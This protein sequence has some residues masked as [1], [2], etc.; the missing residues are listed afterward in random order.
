M[1]FLL[2]ETTMSTWYDIISIL[3]PVE[4]CS[5]DVEYV[6]VSMNNTKKII[7]GFV[8]FRSKAENNTM[9][10]RDLLYTYDIYICQETVCFEHLT[11][12]CEMFRFL[13]LHNVDM[14]WE[15]GSLINNTVKPVLPLSSIISDEDIRLLF[16]NSTTITK[17][18]IIE[19]TYEDIHI[20]YGVARLVKE[21][22][23]LSF[24]MKGYIN[25][26]HI[27]HSSGNQC[28][29]SFRFHKNPHYGL[30]L[31]HVCLLKWILMTA[32]VPFMEYEASETY[33]HN[34]FLTIHNNLIGTQFPLKDIYSLLKGCQ[35]RT[36]NLSNYFISY[37]Y[38]AMF[39]NLR[40]GEPLLTKAI[41]YVTGKRRQKILPLALPIISHISRDLKAYYP[42]IAPDNIRNTTYAQRMGSNFNYSLE[43]LNYFEGFDVSIMYEEDVIDPHCD[44]MNDWRDGYDYLSVVKSTFLDDYFDKYVTV[45]II[46]YTRKAIGDYMY[47]SG[48]NIIL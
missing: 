11:I 24:C 20:S 40:T 31:K 7:M 27:I 35:L 1:L 4:I 30:K 33:Y 39:R 13:V 37:G 12:G 21:T 19:E 46:C 42:N 43:G 48:V 38:S 10:L 29:H 28:Y 47:G 5:I 32:N 22:G 26:V 2:K 15:E 34:E 6:I 23:M 3:Y 9:K 16:E 44:V 25:K 36:R 45:S 14:Y 18:L 41:E 17:V 8:L